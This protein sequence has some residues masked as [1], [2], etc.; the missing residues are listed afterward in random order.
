MDCFLLLPLSLARISYPDDM[1]FWSGGEWR[2]SFSG[3]GVRET[4]MRGAVKGAARVA[5]RTNVDEARWSRWAA[6]DE[7]GGDDGLAGWSGT[8]CRVREQQRQ[9]LLAAGGGRVFAQCCDATG[10]LG[11]SAGWSSGRRWHGGRRD[12][13]EGG[14]RHCVEGARATL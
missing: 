6:T 3:E 5:V 4:W 8:T 1:L 14:Q 12:I 9:P 2:K 7:A 11:G 13:N 10:A